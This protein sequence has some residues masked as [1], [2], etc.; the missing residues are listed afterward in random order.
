MA[1]ALDRL[2]EVLTTADLAAMNRQVDSARRLPADVARAYLEDK[3]L[4]G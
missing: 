2:G 1:K 4:T 3:G